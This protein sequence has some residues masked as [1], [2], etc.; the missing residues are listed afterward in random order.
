[1]NNIHQSTLCTVYIVHAL[2]ENWKNKTKAKSKIY[3]LQIEI[4]NRELNALRIR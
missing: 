3:L 2:K 4:V 1:M